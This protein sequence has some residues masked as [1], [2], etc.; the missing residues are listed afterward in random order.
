MKNLIDLLLPIR[1]DRQPLQPHQPSQAELERQKKTAP[2]AFQFAT[3]PSPPP[4]PIEPPKSLNERAVPI[5][6]LLIIFV[7]I[8][9]LYYFGWDNIGGEEPLEPVS[10]EAE[11][12]IPTEAVPGVDVNIIES[13]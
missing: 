7:I 8:F 3:P 5:I 10:A 13:D 9:A 4:A 2:P 12:P 11:L 1:G 6:I